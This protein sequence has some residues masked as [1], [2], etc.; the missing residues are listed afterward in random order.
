MVERA[1]RQDSS[2]LV[3]LVRADPAHPPD[4]RVAGHTVTVRGSRS[5]LEV[6][7]LVARHAD[8]AGTG[9]G[10]GD[11]PD[12]LL[13]IL[14]DRDSHELGDDLVNRAAGRRI[15]PLDR[16]QAV[17]DLF[18]AQAVAADLGGKLHLVDALVEARPVDGYPPVRSGVLDKETALGA[19]QQVYLG[20]SPDVATLDRLITWA[21]RPEAANRLNRVEAAVLADISEFLVE[22]FGAGAGA[23]LAVLEAGRGADLVPLA[24]VGGILHHPAA[25]PREG[26]QVRLQFEL[27]RAVRPA[28]W[29]ELSRAAERALAAADPAQSHGW[30]QRAER[31]LGEVQASDAAHL[32]DELPSGFAQRLAAAAS[33]LAAWDAAPEDHHLAD[34]AHQAIERAARHR[35]AV[36]EADRVDRLHMAARLVRRGRDPLAWGHTLAEAGRAYQREGAWLDWA[37]TLVSRGESAPGLAALYGTLTARFDTARRADNQAFARIGATA[38]GSLTADVVGVEA[39]LAGVVAPVAAEVPVLLVVLDG[40]SWANYAEIIQHLARVGWSPYRDGAGGLGDRPAVA[41]LPTIT[42]FSRTSLLCGELRSGSGDSEKRGFAAHQALID[43]GTARKPP[44]LWHKRDLRAGGLD[45]VPGDVLAAVEDEKRRVVGVVINNIDERLKDVAQPPSGWG[46]DE[47]DPLRWLLDAARRAGRAV[48]L[49]ADHGHLLERATRQLP[50]PGSGG[51][52]WRPTFEGA[53]AGEDEITVTGPRVVAPGGSAVLPWAEDVRYAAKHNGYH[54][55]LTPQELFVPLAVLAAEDLLPGW[56]PVAVKPPAWWHH[57]PTAPPVA[58]GAATGQ[59]KAP[60][61]QPTLFDAVE[62]QRPQPRPTAPTEHEAW[63]AKVLVALE[64]RR[65]ARIRLRD[66]QA[67]ALLAVLAE[68]AGQA[69]GESRLADLAGLAPTRV[70]GYLAQLQELINV[71]GYAVLTVLG[72]EARLDRPLLD[73]QLGGL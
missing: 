18:G 35:A 53:R 67:A 65:N 43:V 47:L 15:W 2:S 72:G 32:S 38:A 41:A 23:V 28:A 69:V 4:V 50:A 20:L 19:L 59:R 52:R 37:R 66:E 26:A 40:M 16:W 10:E 30:R 22:R 56:E 33:A 68:F 1:L 70:G 34:A 44:L 57:R 31:L 27:S 21:L 6:R 54:G 12:G 60:A 63:A 11:E 51:D 58:A 14:S 62:D 9:V 17:K 61:S 64:P 13:V 24:L 25:G 8:G 48:V 5:P 55:G 49:T 7:A 45:S 71:D 36:P 3:V 29:L 46:L 42:E 73:R 39:V